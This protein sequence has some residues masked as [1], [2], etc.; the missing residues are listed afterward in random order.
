MEQEKKTAP[1]RLTAA[2]LLAGLAAGGVAALYRLALEG[3]ASLMDSAAAFARANAAGAVLWFAALAAMA[4]VVAFLLKKQ[5]LIG[6]QRHPAGGKG[7]ARQG[8]EQL[9]AGA[10]GQVRGRLPQPAGR[11]FARA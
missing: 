7:A 1:L 2:A 10:G 11:A 5:P 9:A 8:A 6:G 3:A 4:A